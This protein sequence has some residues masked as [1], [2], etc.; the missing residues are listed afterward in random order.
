[1]G[2]PLYNQDTTRLNQLSYMLSQEGNFTNRVI[3]SPCGEA[4][5]IAGFVSKEG[6]SNFFNIKTFECTLTIKQLINHFKAEQNSDEINEITKLQRDVDKAR[7]NSLAPYLAKGKTIFPSLTI[8][9]NEADVTTEA[10]IWDTEVVSLVVKSSSDRF[11]ADGQ[12]RFSAFS[13]HYTLLINQLQE[14]KQA[15]DQTDNELVQNL[16]KTISELLSQTVAAKFIVTQT[17]TV[18]EASSIVTQ[19]FADYHLNLK[20][21]S[22]S[23]SLY[24]DQSTAYSR[25]LNTLAFNT[26]INGKLLIEYVTVTGRP[27]IGHLWTYEQLSK[28]ILTIK[29]STRGA[30]STLLDDEVE[31]DK[32]QRI[33]DAVLTK[34]L[35]ALPLDTLETQGAHKEAIF[36]KAL[37]ATGYG[38]FAQSLLTHALTSGKTIDMSV[39]DKVSEMPLST[40][41]DAF[42]LDNKITE[43]GKS[44]ASPIPKC[45]KRIGSTLCVEL[46]VFP[47]KALMA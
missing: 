14:A 11:I 30:F 27:K 45:D 46:S 38:Y 3:T 17:E 22:A 29:G 9:V 2:N 33:L 28:C 34:M 24:F 39:F 37:F 20:K 5:K 6:I 15:D 18:Y 8:F 23:T 35:E 36:T 42:W 41:N 19:V 32:W 1:M 7:L 10:K 16:E 25:L 47:C 12:G 40:M 21:P 43:I 13:A 4:L 44:G 31:F 26:R